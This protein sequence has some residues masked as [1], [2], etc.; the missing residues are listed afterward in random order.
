MGLRNSF[1]WPVYVICC[2][3][4]QLIP[5]FGLSKVHA[6][7]RGGSLV[8]YPHLGCLNNKTNKK[9]KQITNV[10]KSWNSCF[11][12]SSA[13]VVAHLWV[14]ICPPCLVIVYWFGGKQAYEIRTFGK[15]ML[16]YSSTSLISTLPDFLSKM[17]HRGMKMSLADRSRATFPGLVSSLWHMKEEKC[18]PSVTEQLRTSWDLQNSIC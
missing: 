15:N 13:W 8:P 5:A 3:K 2:W 7:W 9:K 6:S 11:I 10:R 17:T 16:A 4:G 14:W 12:H 1:T 18:K